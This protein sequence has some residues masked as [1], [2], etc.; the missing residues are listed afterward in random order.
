MKKILVTGGAG[1]IGSHT[2]VRLIEKRYEVTIID[3][4]DNSNVEVLNRIEQITGTRP[5]F[6]KADIRQAEVLDDLFQV[7]QIDGV[8][9]FAS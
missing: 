7:E 6:V 9:H 8:I 3:N 5:N 2:V 4:L 1:Y